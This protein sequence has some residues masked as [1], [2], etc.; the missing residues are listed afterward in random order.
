MPVHL[1]SGH[2]RRR[3]SHAGAGAEAQEGGGTG[4]AGDFRR[5]KRFRKLS[6]M[7]SN[8]R[9]SRLLWRWRTT[10]G[11]ATPCSSAPPATAT[12]SVLLRLAPYGTQVMRS[13]TRLKWVLIGVAA[14]MLASNLAAYLL[15]SASIKT[16]Q[17]R[18]DDL[19]FVGISCK[20]L[21]ET[22]IDTQVRERAP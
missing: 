10:H 11:R 1:R 19:F 13:V 12:S 21:M 9:V 7:L 4:F 5:G 18:V 2:A 15:M 17:D 22:C 6:K 16:Q 3:Q 8:S 14:V 20:R